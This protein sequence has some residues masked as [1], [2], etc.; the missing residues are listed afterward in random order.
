[1]D[2]ATLVESIGQEFGLALKLN[3]DHVASL[4]IDEK[5]EVEFEFVE[6]LK[7]LFVSSSLG[8][9]QSAGTEGICKALLEA[10]LYGKDTGGAIFS[11]DD[12]TDEVILFFKVEPETIAYEDFR[13]MMERYLNTRSQWI[14]TFD[15]LVAASADKAKKRSSVS[16]AF[17]IDSAI[18]I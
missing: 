9:L 2:A 12:R 5:F 4:I 8:R 11:I 3:K 14:A 15:G 17:N 18:R 16:E 7:T 1:M 6:S 10:N 13:A